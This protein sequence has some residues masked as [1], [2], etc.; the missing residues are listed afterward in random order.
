[1]L[2]SCLKHASSYA[3]SPLFNEQT[4]P[5]VCKVSGSARR[6]SAPRRIHPLNSCITPRSERLNRSGA[7]GQRAKEACSINKSLSALGDVFAALAAKS[8]HVPYR[9][10]KLTQ[11]LQAHALPASCDPV[12][13][14]HR[15]LIQKCQ[16]PWPVST[17]HAFKTVT[18][19]HEP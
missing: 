2:A 8:P 18:H 10:S 15:Y 19:N 1:M 17:K 11:L 12:A 6:G 9:N 7:E 5:F 16:L 14:S 4:F 3:G 13:G